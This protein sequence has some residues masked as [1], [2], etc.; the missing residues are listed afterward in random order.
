LCGTGGDLAC[1]DNFEGTL[2]ETQWQ[3]V[4]RDLPSRD[5]P[6]RDLPSHDLPSHDREGVV[7]LHGGRIRFLTGAARFR[8]IR[9]LTGAAQLGVGLRVCLRAGL[10]DV[11]ALLV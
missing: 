9:F 1:Q 7:I 11:G 2:A 3:Q 6:S 5:L 10:C 4:C 8:G